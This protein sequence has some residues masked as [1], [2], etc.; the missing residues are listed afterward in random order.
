MIGKVMLGSSFSNCI[1]YCLEDKKALSQAEKELLSTLEKVQ[2]QDRAEVLAYNNCCGDKKELTEQFT[3]VSK[4]SKRVEKPVLHLTLR[5]APGDQLTKDQ[6]VEIGQA[7]AKE[8]GVANNQYICVLHQ[9]TRQPHIHIVAN[10]VGYDGKVVSDSNSYARMAA[11]CRRLEKEY[12]LR[13]VLSPRRYLSQE[14]RLV[15]RQ[16]QR[17]ELL[18]ENIRE[19]LKGTRIYPEFEKKMQEKGYRVEKGR[20]IAFEDDKKVRV[21]GSEVGY[22]LQT[23]Q[24]TLDQNRQQALRLSRDWEP[25]EKQPTQAIKQQIFRSLGK[26]KEPIKE[27]HIAGSP[28]KE[29]GHGLSQVF[30]ILMKPELNQGSG[31]NPWEEEERRKKKK[32]LG[33]HISF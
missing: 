11:L 5:T 15:P 3:D 8:F 32:S 30:H 21:K 9:D 10:R 20:G 16:D 17:K 13:P 29:M 28:D 18:K 23:I 25:R 27:H 26:M 7:A 12:H 4:L 22:S 19:A 33:L 31:F 1:R 14:E 2:H 24:R 6:W